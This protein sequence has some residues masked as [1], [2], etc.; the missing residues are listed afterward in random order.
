MWK[1]LERTTNAKYTVK[2]EFSGKLLLNFKVDK[3]NILSK[4]RMSN[5]LYF[6][7]ISIFIIEKFPATSLQIIYCFVV[8]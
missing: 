3:K 8:I 2:L 6:F 7:L 5:Q 4:Q 1:M